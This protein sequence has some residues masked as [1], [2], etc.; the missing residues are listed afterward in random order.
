[1]DSSF[2]LLFCFFAFLILALSL[3]NILTAIFWIMI[4]IVSWGGVIAVLFATLQTWVIRQSNQLSSASSA[5]NSAIL[6]Y[7]IAVGALIG[8]VL[9]RHT[10]LQILVWVSCLLSMLTFVFIVLSTTISWRTQS[11]S[12]YQ[13]GG[14]E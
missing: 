7:C 2:I 1:M 3:S 5:L 4:A 6:N 10:N 13:S 12:A 14:I 8:A 11:D 9:I